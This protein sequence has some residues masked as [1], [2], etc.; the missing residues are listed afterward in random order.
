MMRHR[1]LNAR[2]TG[3]G[4]LLLL[5][6][7]LAAC[8]DGPGPDAAAAQPAPQTAAVMPT[9]APASARPHA[10]VIANR[11][12]V[13]SGPGGDYEIIGV[14]SN[15][16]VLEVLGE[17]GGCAWLQVITP[18]RREGWVD[19]AHVRLTA[20][21]EQS[22]AT[23]GTGATWMPVA[24]THEATVADTPE[25]PVPKT[26]EA[27]GAAAAT[28][29]VLTPQDTP[30]QTPAPITMPNMI[31]PTLEETPTPTG[32]PTPL[33]ILTVRPVEPILK[34]LPLAVPILENPRLIAPA[35]EEPPTPTE[36]Q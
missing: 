3:L 25:T 23:S 10:V 32:T 1:N 11:L 26:S 34:A 8:G 22:A 6:Y 2:V 16:N 24:E 27:S 31:I 9:Q 17:F 4:K 20:S 19:A 14:A 7:A 12:L 35:T 29:P 36:A 30:L 5:C 28:V 18:A 15:G 21:C 13:R 33:P